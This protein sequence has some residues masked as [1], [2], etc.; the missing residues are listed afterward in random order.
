MM[1]TTMMMINSLFCLLYTSSW[2]LN[3][4]CDDGDDDDGLCWVSQLCNYIKRAVEGTAL[5]Y[6]LVD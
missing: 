2:F 3:D 5:Y 4:E 6:R 1:V